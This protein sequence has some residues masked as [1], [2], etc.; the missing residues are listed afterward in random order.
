EDGAEK[1]TRVV[2]I[3][4]LQGVDPFIV[5][6]AVEAI[7]GRPVSQQPGMMGGFGNG[8]QPGFA[9]PG[10][11][12]GFQGGGGRGL[13]G[14]GFGGGVGGGGFPGGLQGGGGFGG[15]RGFGGGGLAP[16]GGGGRGFGGGGGRGGGGRTSS[17][18]TPRGH[19]FFEQRV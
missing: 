6:Q 4:P 1:A 7:Q 8:F 9:R 2:K 14:G 5:Q 3:V 15:G 12:G 10:G 18:D 11:L 16:G 13:R 17:L 19:D